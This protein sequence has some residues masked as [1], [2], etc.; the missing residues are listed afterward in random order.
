MHKTILYSWLLLPRCKFVCVVIIDSIA[1]ERNQREQ[2]TAKRK[3]A[4]EIEEERKDAR[5][6][7]KKRTE[8]GNELRILKLP[9]NIVVCK[10]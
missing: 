6:K 9:V 2:E 5:Q 10:F 7:K 8:P 3:C 1:K 4:V